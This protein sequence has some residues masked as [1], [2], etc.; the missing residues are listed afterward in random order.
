MKLS[1]I[2]YP[3]VFKYPFKIAHGIRTETPC[4]FVK[5]E[6]ENN[7]GYGEC[8]L[9]PYLK[10][11][12]ESSISFLEK[13]DFSIYENMDFNPTEISNEIDK[14]YTENYPIKAAINMALWDLKGKIEN[15]LVDTYFYTN[16][17]TPYC[18]YTIGVSNEQEIK[19][20]IA[21]SSNF[22]IYKLKLDGINDFET[23]EYFTKYSDKP[24]A[25]DA[26]QCWKSIEEALEI[27]ALLEQKKCFL[28][29]QPFDKLD[30][31]MSQLLKNKTKIPIIADEAFQHINQLRE[32]SESFDGINIK[33]MK[34]GG[35]SNAL[36]IIKQAKE[37]DLKILIGCMSESACGCAA[38]SMLQHD[39]D[40]LDLDGPYL[41]NNN[42]FDGYK[43]QNGKIEIAGN[44]GIGL[45]TGLF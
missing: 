14:N 32:L 7:V 28:I 38:G 39:A 15:K 27:V 13:I 5:L 30:R 44:I 8:T 43:I 9:P 35:I 4:L 3:L 31:E 29:E 2:Q 24:F 34:C 40:W 25:I 21:S 10:D 42:P 45:E 19:E 20:K 12:I 16:K 18:T 1:Y 6:L 17:K 36:E 23:I 22:E 37:L 26:N 11:T 41:I 33:L